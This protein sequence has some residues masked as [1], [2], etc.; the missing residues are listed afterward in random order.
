MPIFWGKGISAV[1]SEDELKTMVVIPW[2]KIR[3]LRRM[4]LF[5]ISVCSEEFK[6]NEQTERNIKFK[7]YENLPFARH[8]TQ[9]G[10]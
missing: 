9:Q 1:D 7:R 10:G 2:P 4:I 6:Q 5:R 3:T 8:Q